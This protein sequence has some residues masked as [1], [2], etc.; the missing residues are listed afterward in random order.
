MSD[1]ISQQGPSSFKSEEEL[2]LAPNFAREL[3]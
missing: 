3:V 2:K 1:E